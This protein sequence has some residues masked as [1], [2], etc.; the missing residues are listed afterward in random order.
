MVE[1]VRGMTRLSMCLREAFAINKDVGMIIVDMSTS[2][3]RTANYPR[4]LPGARNSMQMHTFS[5]WC[6]SRM[7][8]A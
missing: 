6:G 2:E 3:V 7:R 5:G 8:F 4:L 1:K